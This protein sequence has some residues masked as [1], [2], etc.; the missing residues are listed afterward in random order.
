MTDCS[1][2]FILLGIVL[3]MMAFMY[4]HAVRET[5][6]FSGFIILCGLFSLII[7]V[8]IIFGKFYS[9]QDLIAKI[10]LGVIVIYFFRQASVALSP[11]K[12][13]DDFSL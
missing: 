3:S 11:V 6:S 1:P 10:L 7:L 13:T 5:K 2:F 9:T 12:T 8:R 4:T